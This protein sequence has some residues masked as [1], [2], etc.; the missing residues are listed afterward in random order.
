MFQQSLFHDKARA[1]AFTGHRML[2]EDFDAERLREE[3]KKKI[4][5]GTY[6][7]LSGMAVGF[8]LLAAEF[9]LA[10]REEIPQ[11]KLIACIPCKDQNKYYSEENKMRY[12]TAL[13]TA[14]EVVTLAE[15]YHL[16]CMRKRNEYMVEN[17]DCLIAYCHKKE[18]GTAST[19]RYFKKQHPD[20]EI[21][22]L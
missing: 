7:F 10:F 13:V 20:G 19:V 16:G 5:E 11:V 15:K 6:V 12:Y 8:D 3:I 21:V 18:G 1:C 14:D 9:V 2:G 17:S 22:F 4:D